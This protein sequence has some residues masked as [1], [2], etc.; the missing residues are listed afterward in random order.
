MNILKPTLMG[1]IVALN[2]SCGD[3]KE[4]ITQTT[5]NKTTQSSQ[6]PTTQTETKADDTA[7][8]DNSV[9]LSYC[10]TSYN[11][12]NC[13]LNK[14]NELEANGKNLS[15]TP[16]VTLRQQ[17]KR[18]VSSL[19]TFKKNNADGPCKTTMN[20][21]DSYIKDNVNFETSED[22][23]GSKNFDDIAKVYAC[24]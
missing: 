14:I 3:V 13:A 23:K 17:L 11:R 21:L 1:L 4:N 8:K 5:D 19:N 15:G 6:T 7:S 10:E 9:S 20:N 16:E 22:L 12:T 24:N 2:T 18:S